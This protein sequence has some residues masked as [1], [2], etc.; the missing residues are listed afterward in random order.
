MGKDNPLT[1]QVNFTLSVIF[2]GSVTLLAIIT[3]L[4]AAEMENP[5]ARHN[6]AIEEYQEF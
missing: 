4:E 1:Q 6:A 3:I 2:L 5:F